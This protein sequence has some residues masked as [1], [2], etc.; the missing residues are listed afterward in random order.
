MTSVFHC[1]F[2]IKACFCPFHF[3][4][5]IP[6][7]ICLYDLQLNACLGQGRQQESTGFV[8]CTKFNIFCLN[9]LNLL[10]L[11]HKHSFSL[12]EVCFLLFR[13]SVRL[14][15]V[16]LQFAMDHGLQLFFLLKKEK[17]RINQI[18]GLCDAVISCHS[19][20]FSQSAKLFCTEGFEQDNANDCWDVQSKSE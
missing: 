18:P 20:Q 3:R 5:Y 6:S 12:C 11:F 17:K 4:A 15:F 19:V 13:G 9:L 2:E 10:N 1:C 16:L 8:S 14:S 7:Q